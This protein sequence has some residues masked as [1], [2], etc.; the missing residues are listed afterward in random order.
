MYSTGRTQLINATSF[1]YRSSFDMENS[2]AIA[3]IARLHSN[4]TLP[5]M[6]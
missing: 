4:H 3:T 2:K 5:V 1:R 6:P